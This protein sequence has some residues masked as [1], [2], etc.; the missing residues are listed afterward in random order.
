[1]K[2]TLDLAERDRRWSAAQAAMTADGLDALIVG[3]TDF[4]GQK[5]GFRYLS[6]ER[7][8]HRY[9][10]ALMIAGRE[11]VLVLHPI[12]AHAPR[13]AW[14]RDVR[15]PGHAGTHMAQMLKA[16]G[17]SRVGLVAADQTLRISDHQALAA[18]PGVQLVDADALFE[19]VRGP[20]SAAEIAGLQEAADIADRCFGHLLDIA[21]PGMTERDIS[22]KLSDMAIAAGA[23]ELLFLTM[24]GEPRDGRIDAR[25]RAPGDHALD[26]ARPFVFSVELSG[27]SGFWVELARVLAFQG[28][29]AG[30]RETADLATRSVL[31]ARALI[32]DGV[33]GP[34]IQAALESPFDAATHTVWN[35]SGHAIG[36]DVIEAPMIARGADTAVRF[37]DGMAFAMH[38][39]FS[40]TDRPMAGYVADTYVL[41]PAGCRPLSSW[42]LELYALNR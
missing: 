35:G 28:A 12:L 31:A 19:T 15:F 37:R 34:D 40:W 8:F 36:H 7:P 11:P 22:G 20:K 25:I 42:P 13:G 33:A 5:G 29:G 41:E 23:E 10:Y 4:R 9:G 14:I 26:A 18:L 3:M 24:S 1:V 16:A 17:A 32:R 27:P 30:V 38:P 2:T 39:L 21:R 6:D